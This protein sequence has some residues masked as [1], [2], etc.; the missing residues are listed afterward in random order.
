MRGSCI[1]KVTPPLKRDQR[2]SSGLLDQGGSSALQVRDVAEFFP[3]DVNQRQCPH[4]DGAAD[5]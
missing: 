3:T 4:H 2:L 5:L 1:P